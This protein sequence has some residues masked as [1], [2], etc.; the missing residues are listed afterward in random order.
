MPYRY[1]AQSI[2]GFI[3]QLAV[4]YVA[5]G[6]IFYVSGVIPERKPVAKTDAKILSKYGIAL[7]PASRCRR[8]RAG[9]ARLHYL[10][11]ERFFVVLATGDG[12]HAFWS[13]E[14]NV[15]DIRSH[16]LKYGGYAVSFRHST[17]TGRGHAS[18][19]VERNEYQELKRFLL[20]RATAS[21]TDE[22]VELFQSLPYEPYA[23]VRRQLLRLV[24]AVN[25]ARRAACRE[26]VPW[27]CVRLSRRA[28]RPFEV[29]NG[30][31]S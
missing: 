5:R 12:T 23:P 14:K 11:H 7:S 15:K 30:G 2:A 21:S 18:V 26:A 13:E 10:R 27:S 29:I 17:V 31:P 16:P 6:Y 22:L 20:K 8:R 28:V 1:E 25:Q 3:Q 4:G 24:S 19:R 9:E